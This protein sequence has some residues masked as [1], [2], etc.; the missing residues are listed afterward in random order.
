M[1]K[2]DIRK[3]EAKEKRSAAIHESSHVAMVFKFGGYAR[4]R[5]WQNTSGHPQ[6]KAWLGQCQIL[7]EPGS[8][9]MSAE[10]I[11]QFK[12]LPAPANWEALVGLA[13]IVGERVFCCDAEDDAGVIFDE[14]ES[15]MMYGD[16][17]SSTD[18]QMIGDT[19]LFDDVA[20][21]V[22][23]LSAMRTEI[24]MNVESLVSAA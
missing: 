3:L 11:A 19:I 10:H 2:S 13:G 17:I 18:L 6:E 22:E 4:A 21:V 8:V 15:E 1:K 23:L 5:I 9:E 12:I 20:L 14:I 24:M 16:E 7:G